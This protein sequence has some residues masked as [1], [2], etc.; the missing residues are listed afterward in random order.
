MVSGDFFSG[1][2]VGSA[3][4]R[5]FSLPEEQKHSAVAVVSYD[6]WNRRLAANCGVVGNTVFIKGNPFTII[7][8]SAK[9]F[10]GVEQTPTDIWVPLQINPALNAWG[11]QDKLLRPNRFGGAFGLWRVWLQA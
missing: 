2:G 6:Y 4:G 9:G 3:C 5:S 10:A 7:G 1:L 8:V 11:S